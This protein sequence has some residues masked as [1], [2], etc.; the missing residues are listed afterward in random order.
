MPLLV[1]RDLNLT[2]RIADAGDVVEQTVDVQLLCGS[3]HAA[4]VGVPHSYG[5][6]VTDLE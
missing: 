4:T 5:L 2:E 3:L 6:V 1:E